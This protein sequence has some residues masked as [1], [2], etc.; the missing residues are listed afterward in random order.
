MVVTNISDLIEPNILIQ[1]ESVFL[2]SVSHYIRHRIILKTI[3]KYTYPRDANT[4]HPSGLSYVLRLDAHHVPLTVGKWTIFLLS[5]ELS[6]I[7]EL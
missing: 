1:V 4:H 5:S 6:V 2:R 7:A 3:K